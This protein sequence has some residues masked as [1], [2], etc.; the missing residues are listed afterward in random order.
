MLQVHKSTP[1]MDAGC[2]EAPVH[3]LLKSKYDMKNI[4]SIRLF[5]E[6]SPCTIRLKN[7]FFFLIPSPWFLLVSQ[8]HWKDMSLYV[9]SFCIIFILLFLNGSWPGYCAKTFLKQWV[10][11]SMME[12]GQIEQMIQRWDEDKCMFEL[13]GGDSGAWVNLYEA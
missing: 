13:M 8:A 10:Q 7:T 9:T 12:K 6:S 11:H 1:T 4:V 3:L 2:S 5:V